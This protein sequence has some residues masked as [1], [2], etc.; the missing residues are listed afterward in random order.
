L[1]SFREEVSAMERKKMAIGFLLLLLFL[2]G[3]L[4]PFVAP[5][6]E[7]E[8]VRVQVAGLV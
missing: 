7:A 2:L 8:R 1:D 3:W 6:V 4:Q 5:A